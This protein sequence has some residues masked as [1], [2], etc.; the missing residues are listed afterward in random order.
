MHNEAYQTQ[1]LLFKNKIDCLPSHEIKYFLLLLA[2][3]LKQKPTPYASNVLKAAMALTDQCHAFLSVNDPSLVDAS[4]KAVQQRY[5]DLVQIAGTNSAQTQL[6]QGILNVGGALAALILGILGGL[7]GGF[8]G[9]LRAGARL[10]N[11]FNHAL[12]GFITGF[13]VGAMIGFRA[14]KKLFKEETF[15]QIKYTLDGLGRSL[16]HLASSQ[17]Q[18]LNHYLDKVK[19]RLLIEYFNMNQDAL[20]RF[21]ESPQTYEI[22][23]FEARFISDALRGYVGH[24]ALIKLAI[25]DKHLALEFSL[26]GSDLKQ[27][28]VQREN[29]QVDGRQLVRMMALHEH[30]QTTHACTK[31]FIATRMKPGE[32]D[33]LSY[34]NLILTGTNQPATTLKRLTAQDSLPGKMIGFFATCFSPFPQTALAAQDAPLSA[35]TPD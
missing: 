24:H 16:N 13:F 26:G 4:L 27:A 17:Y 21:L 11:P 22:V 25:G 35:L 7:I 29:R 5:Q 12:I 31:R 1:L 15:R 23:T 9:L 30:L 34:V 33:C 19:N 10:E 6:I 18:P 2:T 32:T 8:S 3:T 28:P 20:D 14:P